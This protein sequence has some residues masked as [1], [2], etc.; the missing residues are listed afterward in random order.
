M[1]LFSES[2]DE[3]SLI[4]IGSDETEN[5][6]ADADDYQNISIARPLSV[7]TWPLL[8]FVQNEISATD[9]IADCIHF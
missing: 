1:Q 5:E 6:L 7:V 4:L 2:K 8:D 9:N 3:V